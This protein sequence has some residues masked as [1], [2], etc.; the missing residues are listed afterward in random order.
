MINFNTCPVV[1]WGYKNVYH[2]HGHIHEGFYRILRWMVRE[3]YWLD[4][5]DDVSGM[6]F[7]RTVFITNHDRVDPNGY[8][9]WPYQKR[10][11]IPIRDD[12][13]YAVHGLHDCP[14]AKEVLGN[15]QSL[16]WNVYHNFSHIYG[17]AAEFHPVGT[18]SEIQL[19]D[20]VMLDRDVPFYPREHRLDFR[21]ATDLTPDECR[22]NKKRACLLNEGSS[23]INWVG[24]IWHVNQQ[25]LA[26]FARACSQ[27]GITFQQ[28]GAGQNGVLTL[29]QKAD[30]VRESY[31]APA[32]SGT[33]HLTEGYAP[34]RIF[35]NISYG[36]MGI[37]NSEKVQAVFDG[38]L[39]FDPDPY[40]LFFTAREQLKAMRIEQLHELMDYVADHHTYVNR[41]SCVLQAARII[42]EKG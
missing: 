35:E 36:R 39:I 26:D 6:D 9:P 34:P 29:S 22:E 37:T 14:P 8:W 20:R 24:T 2:T 18:P 11:T 38:R 27:S 33:H 25:E 40:Q 7:S 10:S 13:F 32:I 1:V 30:K 15:R 42:V 28:L 21:W 23:T 3:A 12:C 19:T 17:I 31:F 4:E 16:G 41:L 5:L